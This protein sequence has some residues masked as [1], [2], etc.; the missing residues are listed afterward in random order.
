MMT[1]REVTAAIDPD[2]PGGGLNAYFYGD[3]RVAVP[4]LC[5]VN[6]RSGSFP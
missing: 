2:T 5:S 6:Q 4:M 3:R 1:V